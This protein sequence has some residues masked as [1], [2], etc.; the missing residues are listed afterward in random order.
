MQE[1]RR[2]TAVN[3]VQEKRDCLHNERCNLWR[4][5]VVRWPGCPAEH[6]GSLD[7]LAPPFALRQKVEKRYKRIT[8][9]R[10]KLSPSKFK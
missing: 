1:G 5:A 9:K 8:E 7:F 3:C 10:E 2:R 6:R 4:V